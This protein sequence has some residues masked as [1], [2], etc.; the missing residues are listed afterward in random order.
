MTPKQI[1]LIHASWRQ[2]LPIKDEA[3]KLFYGKL[4]ELDPSV[5]PLFKGDLDEQGKKLMS[6]LNFV[7]VKLTRLDELLPAVKELGRRHVTYGVTDAHY[8]TVATALLWTLGAGL[9]DEFTNETKEAWTKAYD[10]LATAMKTAAAE[11]IAQA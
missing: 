3:A 4:F 2:V 8:D 10:L 5:R 11:V 6:M 1:E 7:V 9:G